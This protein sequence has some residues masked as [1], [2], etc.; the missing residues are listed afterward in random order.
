MPIGVAAFERPSMLAAI[1]RIIAPIGRVVGRDFWKQQAAEWTQ[2]RG[3]EP[4]SGPLFCDA[5]D[6]EPQRPSPR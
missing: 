6:A 1:F 4:R 5:H 2:A 3:R